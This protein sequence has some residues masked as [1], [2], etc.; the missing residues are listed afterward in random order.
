MAYKAI[1]LETRS[2]KGCGVEFQTTD[3]RKWLHKKGCGRAKVEKQ[4]NQWLLA[5]RPN[6]P[7]E[8]CLAC[9][10]P[11]VQYRTRRYDGEMRY[12]D[13]ACMPSPN[14]PPLAKAIWPPRTYGACS[15]IP[16]GCSECRTGRQ[17][18]LCQQ[19]HNRK[20]VLRQMLSVR[21]RWLMPRQCTQCSAT[22]TKFASVR[23]CDECRDHNRAAQAK[24][25][26]IKRKHRMTGGDSDI[27][28]ARL[29]ERDQRMCSLCHRVTDHPRVWKQWRSS[30]KWMPN[31]PT[32]D[33]IIPLAKG[34]THTWENVQ[35]AHWS[36]N[37]DKSDSIVTGAPV[38]LASNTPPVPSAE[39]V[40]LL[41]GVGSTNG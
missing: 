11:V 14:P 30:N 15:A 32:V 17:A 8:P 40:N 28:P 41:Y 3:P 33:H 38:N 20:F 16:R 34:G 27:S 22:F 6:F 21:L 19:H 4:T 26:R 9:G 25:M 39:F 7:T 18:G 10:A 36:C 37:G 13:R 31:A 24:W 35:L 29:Y 2:C 5:N 1:P 12:C 23:L